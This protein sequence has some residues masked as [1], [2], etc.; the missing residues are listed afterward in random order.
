MNF[1]KYIKTLKLKTVGMVEVPIETI[2]CQ[3][4]PDRYKFWREACGESLDI[5]NGPFWEYLMYKKLDKYNRL[6]KLYGR[7]EV[8]VTNNI[9]KFQKM[10]NDISVN[11]FDEK[12]GFPIIL[13][14]P[15]I[16]NKYSKG[17]EI[18][19]GHRRLS[20]CLY[21]GIKQRVKLCKIIS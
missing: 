6:F 18:F 14:S 12:K 21:L 8:W 3:Y 19:E 2:S 10:Y 16:N 1:A 20:I 15:V 11:G 4:N 7:S 9:L 13:G 17:H 5:K